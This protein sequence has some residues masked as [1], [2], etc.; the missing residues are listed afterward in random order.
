MRLT[1]RPCTPFRATP[2][3]CQLY[4][5]TRYDRW[6]DITGFPMDRCANFQYIEVQ[7]TRYKIESNH[8]WK[9]KCSASDIWDPVSPCIH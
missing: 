9:E 5:F 3:L 1:T 4:V 7:A 6:L 8:Y 2:L